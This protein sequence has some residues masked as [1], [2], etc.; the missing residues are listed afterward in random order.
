MSI[1]WDVKTFTSLPSTQ[2][3]VKELADEGLHEGLVIQSL[4]QT[5]GR[6]RHGREWTSPMGNLYMS[7]L[8]RPGCESVDAGQLAFVAAL[9]VARAVEDVLDPQYQLTLKWPNDV[10][11]DGRKCS[12]L[13]LESD[14]RDG[15]LAWVALGMGINILSCPDGAVALQD[16]SGKGQIPIH[17]FRDTVLHHLA[18]VY[19]LWTE[20]GFAPIRQE[21]L[22]KAHGLDK[23]I[24]VTIPGRENTGIFKTIDETGAL[25]LMTDKGETK[26]YAGDV[27]VNSK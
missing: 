21:W 20:M 15:E 4:I 27:F 2:D 13:L 14:I 8:L 24:K 22:S 6:G 1:S 5:K 17:P 26:I 25:I 18:D 11:I 10:L 23:E 9:A 19:D 12:G 7:V 3:Y 16:V